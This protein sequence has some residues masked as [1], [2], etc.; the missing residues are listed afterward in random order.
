MEEVISAR[1]TL[2]PPATKAPQPAPAVADVQSIARN[3]G[4]DKSGLSSQ[5]KDAGRIVRRRVPRD[6]QLT[7]KIT[8]ETARWMREHANETGLSLPD[9][10]EEAM[11][12]Y[13]QL[14]G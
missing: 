10:I 5:F 9:I 13:R 6:A 14:K 2:L 11:S 12:H 1:K 7:I 4:F 8:T 3:A